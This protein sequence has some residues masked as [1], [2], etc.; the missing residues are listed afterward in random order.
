MEN[1][2]SNNL[3]KASVLWQGAVLIK[4]CD[5]LAESVRALSKSIAQLKEP[6]ACQGTGLNMKFENL[7]EQSQQSAR[8]ALRSVLIVDFEGRNDLSEARAEYLARAIRKSFIALEG[9]EVVISASSLSP[10]K[11]PE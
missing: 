7:S 9:P 6:E 5:G 10:R 11:S 1:E 8:D 2:S 4:Q 3:S